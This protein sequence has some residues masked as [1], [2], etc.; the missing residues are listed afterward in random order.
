MRFT[1][2]ALAQILLWSLGACGSLLPA[3]DAALQQPIWDVHAQRFITERELVDRLTRA[4]FKL[5]GEVHDNPLHHSLRAQV[6]SAIGATGA[7]PAVVMEQFDLGSDDALIAA[8]ARGTDAE[9]LADTGK[10]NRGDWGWPLHRPIVDAAL[11]AR[12]PIRAGNLSDRELMRIA[13]AGLQSAPDAAWRPRF[14]ATPW[15]ERE[16]AG[17]RAE[18]GESH[19]NALPDA[20]VPTL[21]LAQR[22]RDAAMAQALVD[23]A[24]GDGAILIAGNGHV[25]NDLGVP[26]YL[27]APGMPGD[28]TSTLSVG[29]IEVSAEEG[30]SDE[31]PKNV[32]AE[33]A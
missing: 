3:T 11:A 18:I 4:R 9:Q 21:V 24:T 1:R 14:D 32:V 5:L 25:R 30:R 2:I 6:V 12:M 28:R 31:F 15:G 27:Q 13:R 29:W 17:L 7:R 26:R 10:L 19:C 20:V 22:V 33:H 16:A 23:A 8:Q